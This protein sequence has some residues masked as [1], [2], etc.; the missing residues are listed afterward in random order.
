MPWCDTYVSLSLLWSLEVIAD[1]ALH[2]R[3]FLWRR[4]DEAVACGERC[5]G[6]VVSTADCQSVPDGLNLLTSTLQSL[7]CLN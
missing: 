7:Q 1:D 5:A 4:S 6:T 3:S 2:L